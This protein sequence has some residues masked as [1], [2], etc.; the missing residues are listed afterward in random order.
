MSVRRPLHHVVRSVEKRKIRF[1]PAAVHKLNTR[2]SSPPL[3]SVSR[4]LQ[5]HKFS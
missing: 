2:S 3:P 1:C 5:K 4:E